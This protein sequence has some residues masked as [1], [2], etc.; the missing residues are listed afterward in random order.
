MT[1]DAAGR[2]YLAWTERVRRPDNTCDPDGAARIMVSTSTGRLTWS[3]PRQA[4]P[5]STFE[6]QILPTIAFTAGKLFLAWIDF[7]EDASGVFGKYV[8]ETN[9]FNPIDRTTGDTAQSAPAHV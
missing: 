1:M 6:H 3:S 8:E 4:S 2:A 5:S 7:G 9:L